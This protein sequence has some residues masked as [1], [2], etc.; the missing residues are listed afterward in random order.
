MNNLDSIVIKEFEEAD[1]KEKRS[2][3]WIVN[4]D[5]KKKEKEKSRKSIQ[6]KRK[7]KRKKWEKRKKEKT[8]RETIR[9]TKTN[10]FIVASLLSGG[11][12]S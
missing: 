9:D 5:V 12:E 3:K 8:K 10:T 7:W 1:K 11:R 2:E 6:E 4:F